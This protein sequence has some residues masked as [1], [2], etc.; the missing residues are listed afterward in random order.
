MSG[1]AARVLWSELLGKKGLTFCPSVPPVL[2]E[3]ESLLFDR[4]AGAGATQSRYFWLIRYRSRFYCLAPTPTLTL[5]LN[6]CIN[7]KNDRF[8]K[9]RGNRLKKYR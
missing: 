8:N 7:L 5:L 6:I 9:Y 2:S 4:V 1:T 3:Q